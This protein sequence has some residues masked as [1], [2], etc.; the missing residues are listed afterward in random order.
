MA[1]HQ[2]PLSEVETAVQSAVQAV[3]SKHNIGDI[4]KLWVGFVAPENIANS[5]ANE[6]AHALGK[7][8]T[9]AVTPSI[10]TAQSAVAGQ[11][12]AEALPHQ[13]KIIGLIYD[14]RAVK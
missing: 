7:G 1:Q 11:H 12:A 14:P 3:L 2:I 8:A 5:V 4:N 6:V 10:A 9:G 13:V